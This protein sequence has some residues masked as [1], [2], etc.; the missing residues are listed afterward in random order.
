MIVNGGDWTKLV[1]ESVATAIKERN[2][3]GY[4]G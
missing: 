3:F 2:L 1:P 4:T